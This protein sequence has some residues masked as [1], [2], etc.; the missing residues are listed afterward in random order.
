MRRLDYLIAAALFGLLIL[1]PGRGIA[2]SDPA[3][4]ALGLKPDTGSLPLWTTGVP[5]ARTQL[6][7]K[8]RTQEAA[9]F[10]VGHPKVGRGTAWVISKK[11]RLLA[12]NAHVADIQF[13]AGS[14]I[15]AISAGHEKMIIASP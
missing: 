9:V 5:S 13:R 4:K 15:M 10:L 6:G 1:I 12:T 14:K 2:Q 3:A 8:V 11:H 7:N